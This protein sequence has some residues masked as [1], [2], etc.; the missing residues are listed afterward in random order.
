[1]KIVLIKK[2]DLLHLSNLSLLASVIG[3]LWS[4]KY[5]II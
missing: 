4:A 3:T 2:I 1:L 5:K